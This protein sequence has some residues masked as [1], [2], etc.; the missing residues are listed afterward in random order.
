N[1]SASP[2]S[3]A[4][5]AGSPSA[6]T[7]SSQR[8]GLAR[9][10]GRENGESA[11]VKSGGD[12]SRSAAS[13][14][15]AESIARRGRARTPAST[16]CDLLDAREQPARRSVRGLREVP[17]LVERDRRGVGLAQR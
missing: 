6:T 15:P 3:V 13:A 11:S 1:V 10:A 2:L 17:Y 7:S 5:S 9:K 4:A 8:R 16:L 14:F 12:P